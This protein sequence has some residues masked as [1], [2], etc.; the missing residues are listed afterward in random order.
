MTYVFLN[1]QLVKKEDARISVEDRG[2]RYGDGVFET[3]AVHGGVPYQFDWH[4]ERLSAGLAAIKLPCDMNHM[5]E[6]CR[7]LLRKN[8][9]GEGTLR[10]Q[11]TRGTG[12]QG[13][14]PTGSS[15]TIV[16][17]TAALPPSPAKSVK[18]WVSAAQKIAPGALPVQHKLCQGLSSTLARIEAAEKRCFDALMLNAQGHICETGGGNIFWVKDGVLYTPALSCGVLSGSTRAAVLRLSPFPM[19]EITANLSAIE[20]ADAIFITNTAWKALAVNRLEPLGYCWNSADITQQ[21]Y[22][23]LCGDREHYAQAHRIDW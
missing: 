5:R 17:E 12:S 20:N 1:H 22:M 11:V 15:P 19:Q 10:I 14:L 8:Q 16:I 6:E 18:L 23:L 4:M 9:L 13:Y 3:L 21:F 7:V 2:F